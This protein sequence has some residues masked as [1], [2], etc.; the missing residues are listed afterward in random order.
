MRRYLRKMTL[1][2]KV[3]FSIVVALGVAAMLEGGV[4]VWN[5]VMNGRW[6]VRDPDS[7]AVNKQLYVDHI[8][9]GQ[10]PRPGADIRTQ[11]RHITINTLGYRGPN[12]SLAKPP[13]VVRIACIGG[14]TTFDVK[15]SE[16][17]KA[18]PA[19]L[20][21]ELQS[22]ADLPPTEVINAAT[23][24]Y[25]L[26]RTIID[27]E[28]RTLDIKPDWV[29]CYPGVNDVAYANRPSH[30]FGEAHRA[31][32]KPERPL[33]WTTVLL[34]H[35]E[36]FNEITSR[37]QYAR[38]VR[39]GNWWG[40]PVERSDMIDP[41][42]IEAFARNLTTL[43]AICEAHGIKLALVTVRTA[44]APD[45]PI[46]EQERLARGDLMDHPHLSLK[47]HYAGYEEVNAMIRHAAEAHGVLL[48]D[49]AVALPSGETDFDDS[50]HFNDAGA[51]AFARYVCELLAPRLSPELARRP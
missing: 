6:T 7:V 5:R 41:R 30:Q 4:R 33:P 21:V 20:G 34:T 9:L 29:I 1:R 51:A 10:M 13:G 47:G 32:D 26:P 35:S 36:I 45:Q 42:G 25:A 22:R 48:I 17:S 11:G 12:F 3:L 2:R 40:R 14:S 27:L 46:E 28:L 43:I 39:F 19:R 18:W 38:Q 31:I 16:D 37:L 23:P 8:W 24:G 15:V 49:Q 44:Y 50:V